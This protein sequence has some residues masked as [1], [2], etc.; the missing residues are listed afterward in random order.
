MILNLTFL[1]LSQ[2]QVPCNQYW[3]KPAEKTTICNVPW[4]LFYQ[5]VSLTVF[6][7]S[8]GK[9]G[10]AIHIPELGATAELGRD[11]DP[12]AAASHEAHAIPSMR[13]KTPCFFTPAGCSVK[14][15]LR[16]PNVLRKKAPHP[17]MG[18]HLSW[19][20]DQ[21]CGKGPTAPLSR[22]S[23]CHAW[24][25]SRTGARHLQWKWPCDSAEQSISTFL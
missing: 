8:M 2:S 20:W 13:G 18:R 22:Q 15:N 9:R 3:G 23:S 4:P 7:R 10:R 1:I 14:Q 12:A 21:S 16:D 17:W 25:S 6:G 19:F 5:A 24:R 11:W